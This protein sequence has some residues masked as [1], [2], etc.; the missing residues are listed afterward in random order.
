MGGRKKV[1]SF[2]RVRQAVFETFSMAPPSLP[3]AVCSRH[4]NLT[5]V[6]PTCFN[7]LPAEAA[8]TTEHNLPPR[9]ILSRPKPTATRPMSA[10]GEGEQPS[11]HQKITNPSW[12][13]PQDVGSRWNE[14]TP[15][16]YCLC[17]LHG[18]VHRIPLASVDF[19]EPPEFSMRQSGKSAP[20][21]PSRF[22][23]L[24][25]AGAGADFAR[26]GSRRLGGISPR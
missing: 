8:L 3:F 12:F 20:L 1:L 25:H 15:S 5:R 22:M 10:M 4:D 18:G 9:R 6:Y 13:S 17:G 23:V 24:C 21:R 2:G 14:T 19:G 16:H 26:V 7:L 11:Y